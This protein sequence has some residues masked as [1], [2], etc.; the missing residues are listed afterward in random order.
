M[1]PLADRRAAHRDTLGRFAAT[2]ALSDEKR[3]AN[4]LF[5]AYMESLVAITGRSGLSVEENALLTG[6]PASLAEALDA[7]LGTQRAAS[8]EEVPNDASEPSRAAHWL[9]WAAGVVALLLS[10]P[11]PA[12]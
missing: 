2:P 1:E 9:L 10:F 5:V 6:T 4:R 12:H 3:Y 7:V 11:L 8:V